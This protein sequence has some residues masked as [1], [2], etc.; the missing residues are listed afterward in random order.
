MSL[1]RLLGK[2]NNRTIEVWIMRPF[3]QSQQLHMPWTCEYG[4]EFAS[5]LRREMVGTLSCNDKAD[6]LYVKPSVF[7]SAER[8]LLENCPVEPLSPFHQTMLDE[9]DQRKVTVVMPLCTVVEL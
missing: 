2:L 1:N 8:L 3:Q 4:A 5:I 7:V 6:M 9:Q